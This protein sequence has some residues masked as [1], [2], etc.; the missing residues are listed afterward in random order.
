MVNF[1]TI[2]CEWLLHL[3]SLLQFQKQNNVITD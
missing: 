2:K 3:I 1:Q